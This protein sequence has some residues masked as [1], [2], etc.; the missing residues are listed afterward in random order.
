[1]VNLEE[2]NE[3]G[4]AVLSDWGSRWVRET[5]NEDNYNKWERGTEDA[6]EGR[7][8]KQSPGQALAAQLG[9]PPERLSTF[10]SNWERNTR[11]SFSDGDRPSRY[12]TGLKGF[13]GVDEDG[14][15][16]QESAN[17]TWQESFLAGLGT[18]EGQ[19]PEEE[20]S[21]EDSDNSSE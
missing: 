6:I 19:G 15:V 20:T 13:A 9:L 3:D 16:D 21:V 8:G 5:F 17:Q 7:A 11:A 10:D 14:E 18:S 4:T 1:M 12:E 2:L